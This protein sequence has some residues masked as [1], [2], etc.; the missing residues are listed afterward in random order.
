MKELNATTDCTD[1]CED[2]WGGG[3]LRQSVVNKSVVDGER[4]E[5]LYSGF[6]MD[7]TTNESPLIYSEKA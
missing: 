4:K 6:Y 7:V 5:F 1:S 3:S 2:F